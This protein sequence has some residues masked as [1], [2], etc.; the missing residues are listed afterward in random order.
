MEKLVSVIVPI[1]KVEKYLPRCIESIL[2]QDYTKLEILLVDDGSPDRSG[3]IADEYAKKDQRIHVIHKK[4]GGLSDARNAGIDAAVGEYLVFI[5]SDDYVH[6]EM[7]SRMMEAVQQTSSDVAVCSFKF[8]KEDEPMPEE[9]GNDEITVISDDVKRTEYMF[10]KYI[11]EFNVAWNKLYP[12]QFFEKIR[13]PFGKIHEDEFTTWKVLEM[14]ERIVYIGEPL[15]FYVQRETSIMGERFNEKR[16]LAL[17][18]YDEKLDHYFNMDRMVWFEKTL[19]LYR[20]CLIKFAKE[21]RKNGL[22][23]AILRKYRQHFKQLVLKSFIKL[24]ISFKK[25]MGYLCCALMPE[26]YLKGH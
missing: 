17:E 25:K 26:V 15:Y 19:F 3:E 14:A 21:M 22:D 12:A 13:Y 20:V 4:N 9:S 2:V 8:V 1:Y 18:A 10:E 11:P 16:F 5:D 23:E 6:P 24:P 7:I